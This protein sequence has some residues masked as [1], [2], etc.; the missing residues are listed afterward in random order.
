M[1][2]E[3]YDKKFVG[4]VE[5]P[6][7]SV[8]ISFNLQNLEELKALA[9]EKGN[10]YG[11]LVVNYD[12]KDSDPKNKKVKTFMSFKDMSNGPNDPTSSDDDLTY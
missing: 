5:G 12:W 8:P 11:E 7:L 1:A 10:I 6:R 3:E 4:F 2:K 9:N